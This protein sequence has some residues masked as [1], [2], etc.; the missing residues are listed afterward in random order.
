MF[1]KKY[2]FVTVIISLALLLSFPATT[3]A[4]GGA[5]SSV[6]NFQIVTTGDDYETIVTSNEPFSL[7]FTAMDD[8]SDE[9]GAGMMGDTSFNTG[10]FYS[11]AV[12]NISELEEY[13][14]EDTV[15]IVSAWMKGVIISFPEAKKNSM[16]CSNLPGYVRLEVVEDAMPISLWDAFDKPV[17]AFGKDGLLESS[18]LALEEH[19]DNMNRTYDNVSHSYVINPKDT[20]SLSLADSIAKVISHV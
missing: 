16:F 3:L 14:G 18:I 4:L 13:A 11:C 7:I 10:C 12:L 19:A 15:K 5:E 6:T 8:L 17:K 1:G 20:N 2:Q 9:G